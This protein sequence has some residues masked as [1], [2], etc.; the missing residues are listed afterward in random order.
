MII[1]Y[2]FEY[3]G[4]NDGFEEYYQIKNGLKSQFGKMSSNAGLKKKLFQI[5]VWKNGF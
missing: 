1:N 4:L 5:T 2:G 3:N